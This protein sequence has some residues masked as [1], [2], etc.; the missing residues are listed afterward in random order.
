M[1]KQERRQNLPLSLPPRGLRREEAAAYIGISPGLFDMMVNDGRM[2]K[3]KQ[4]NARRV[5]DRMEMD[6]AFGAL[7]S[8]DDEAMAVPPLDFRV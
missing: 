3:P 6:L 8:V 4:I 5:W 1:A 2:P 7:P